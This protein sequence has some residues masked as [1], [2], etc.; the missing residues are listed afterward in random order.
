MAG[1]RAD[2]RAARWEGQQERRRREFVDAA[3]R[4]I[5]EHGAEVSTAQI[6]A[7]AGVA[8]TRIYK[9]FE[10]A[11]DLQASIAER[12]LELVAVNLEPVWKPQG[13]A[14]EMISGIIDTL[15]GYLSE[16]RQLYRYLTKYAPSARDSD[17]DVVTD[18]KTAIGNHV[19]GIFRYFLGE[20]DADSR[21]AEVDAFALVGMVES[22]IN[23]WL[24]NPAGVTREELSGHLTRWIWLLIDQVLREAGIELDPGAPL[25]LPDLTQGPPRDGAP[26]ELPARDKQANAL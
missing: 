24:D 25:E 16:H 12:A 2:G 10:D 11:A 9:H 23:Q 4:A 1:S 8:R 20:F 14:M 13:S 17:R 21:L 22:A 6:A 26:A 3:M 18:V 15:I 7:E 5:A 19:T